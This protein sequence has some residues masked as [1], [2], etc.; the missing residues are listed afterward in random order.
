MLSMNETMTSNHIFIYIFYEA[1]TWGGPLDKYVRI[2]H[3]FSFPKWEVNDHVL[4]L[5]GLPRNCEQW[6]SHSH[7]KCKCA[8][9]VTHMMVKGWLEMNF[10][11]V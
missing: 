5:D 1:S 6:K 8:P 2:W 11:I 9:C 10:V 3:S 4:I 7:K